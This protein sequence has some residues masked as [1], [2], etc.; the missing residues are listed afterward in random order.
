ML[1]QT[2]YLLNQEKFPT[3]NSR[4]DRNFII[5]YNSMRQQN[6]IKQTESTM[7]VAATTTTPKKKNLHP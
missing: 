6:A 2:H 5:T 1:L 4:Y 7:A 3:K